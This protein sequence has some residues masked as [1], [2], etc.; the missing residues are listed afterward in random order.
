[1]EEER[2][3]GVPEQEHEDGHHGVGDGR[4]EDRALFLG[5]EGG[6]AL[7]ER[8]SAAPVRARKTVSR[9]TRSSR[10][11]RR[12]RCCATIA[13]ASAS[14]TAAPSTSTVHATRPGSGEDRLTRRT[15]TT[16]C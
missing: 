8:G 16:P 1:D 13:R 12:G 6:E 2:G 14:A 11:S 3:E 7:H 5:E 4:E 15:P 10:S 9:S